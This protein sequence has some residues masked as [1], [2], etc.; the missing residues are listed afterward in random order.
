[1]DLCGIFL[2]YDTT[3]SKSF[4]GLHNIIGDLSHLTS[5]GCEIFLIGCKSDLREQ[6]KISFKEAEDFAIR[7]GFSLFETRLISFI[8]HIFLRFKG[9][10]SYF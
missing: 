2:L 9:N 3:D 7:I 4:D 6:R 1:M 8:L 5:P 10:F